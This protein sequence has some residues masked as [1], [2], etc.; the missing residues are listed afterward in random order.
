M[1]IPPM[2]DNATGI[3]AVVIGKQTW[4]KKNLNVSFFR[5][6]EPIPQATSEQEWKAAATQ[7]LPAWCHYENN[8]ANGEKYGKL[9]NWFAVNDPRGLA[10]EGWRI[11]TANDWQQLIDF[12]GGEE[13]A[14]FA[15][16]AA[17]QFTVPPPGGR[18]SGF[19]GL[20]GGGRNK[21]GSFGN[22][23][24][25]AYW[26][27]CSQHNET[28]AISLQLDSESNTAQLKPSDMGTG[29]GVRCIWVG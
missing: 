16:M 20:A 29:F 28:K 13:A 5:T 12:T 2:K 19:Q 10:P 15:L 18:N 7:G 17:D 1:I 26:W 23:G 24:D 27:S 21:Y 9:Y 4:V 8:P 22:L 14:C 11:P 6:G 3:D 25:F